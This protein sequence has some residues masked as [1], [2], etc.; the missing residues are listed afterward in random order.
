MDHL[1]GPALNPKGDIDSLKT[2]LDHATNHYF[3]EPRGRWV[4]RGHSDAAF[5]LIPSAGRGTPPPSVTREKY[6]RSLFDM[7]RREARA[8]L[9]TLP[10]DQWEWLSIAQHHGLPTRLLDWTHSVLVALY[11][12]VENGVEVD[13]QIFALRSAGKASEAELSSSPFELADPV[14]Y[15]PNV[16]VPRIR[17]QESLF[18]ACA[19][20]EAPLDERLRD[21]WIIECWRVPASRKEQLRYELYRLGVHAAS[22]FPDIDGLARRIRWQHEIS[23]PFAASQFA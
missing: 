8:F 13:G 18:V 12:A 4:F 23:S 22:L 2:F 17:A 19:A 3:A 10:A 5:K 11:F 6:E 9:T 15:Y 7:F 16:V 1:G 20:L 14:K 21:G